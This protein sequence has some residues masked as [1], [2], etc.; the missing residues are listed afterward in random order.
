MRITYAW[1]VA[2]LVLLGCGGKGSGF[3]SDGGEG[4]AGLDGTVGDDACA[5]C[6]FDSGTSE[7]GTQY[8]CSGDLREVIDGNGVVIATCPND[9]GCAGGVCIP[10]CQAAGLSKGTVGCDYVVPTPSF[11]TGI[12]PPCFAIFVANNW[13]SPV[14]ITV[15]RGG[16]NYNVTQF[17][18]IAQAG[19]AATSW[20]PVP[21]TGLPPGD[22]AILFMSQDPSSTNSTPLTCPITPAISKAGG[23]ALPGSGTTPSIT[24][25]GTAWHVST[26]LPVTMY[27]ILPYGGASSYLPSAELL[28]PS[29]SW[30]T[31]YFGIVPQRGNSSPQWGQL[32]A[33]MDGTSVTVFPNV[34]L[35]AGT[36]VVAAPQNKATTYNLNAGQYIQWQESNEMSGTVISSNNPVGFFG[37][38][39]YDCY[40]DTTSSGGGC[41]SA[42]QQVPPVSAYGSEY[43]IPPYTTR[44]ASLAPESIR[45]RFLGAVKGTTL[46]YDPPVPS[47][48][49]TI[50]VGQVV[51]FETTLAFVVKAQDINHPFFVGQVMTG[52]TVTGGSRPG[53]TNSS[54]CCLGDE[55]Y[56]NIL[57]P[58]QFLQKYVFFTDPTYPT[59]NLVFT[60]V[61]GSAGFQ[62]VTLDCY[63]T[64]TGWKNIDGA[65]NY[66]LTNIDLIRG[67]VKTGKCDNGPHTASS[68]GAFG[69][70][71]WGL[72]YCSSYA[73]PAG[74]N[75]APINTVIVPP[76]PH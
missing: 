47:A 64:L 51:D 75:V 26:D 46:T 20:A 8:G 17:G 18:R 35:P 24:G 4:D 58:A 1:S 53:C 55:E 2:A 72:D 23:T 57:P 71:V 70:M 9:Q 37:G 66:Q 15:E 41:D 12:L 27:D 50:G 49:T 59:T 44:M 69:V 14:N 39:G 73:Y 31:N 38:L 29:T 33:S 28:L 30:G 60:R 21:T 7:T 40:S 54:G 13:V 42:H 22:V 36:G 5:F 11:Y 65:G 56:V 48:P 68:T 19:V 43:A 32:V 62:D 16:T 74:G 25:V 6:G 45:Y 3:G 63:G 34:S 61:K 67:N 52:C 76:T 10:A